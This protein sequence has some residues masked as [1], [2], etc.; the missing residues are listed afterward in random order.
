MNMV[1]VNYVSY[2]ATQVRGFMRGLS[3]E[4]IDELTGGLEAD[5]IEAMDEFVKD[6]DERDVTLNDLIARFGTPETY[7]QELCD[8]A[9]IDLRSAGAEATAVEGKQKKTR[10]L[11]KKRVST[12]WQA[13]KAKVSQTLESMTASPMVREFLETIRPVWW[14]LRAWLLYVGITYLESS[15]RN[16]PFPSDIAHWLLLLVVFVASILVGMK[17]GKR[18]SSKKVI[19]S[20]A[21]VNVCALLLAP[22]TLMGTLHRADDARAQGFSLGYD[23]ALNDTYGYNDTTTT[24]PSG[25]KNTRLID[26][27]SSRNLYVYDSEGNFIQDARIMNEDGTAVSASIFPVRLDRSSRVV[28]LLNARKDQYGRDVFNVFPA[29]YTQI[30][31]EADTCSPADKEFWQ[32]LMDAIVFEDWDADYAETL[33]DAQSQLGTLMFSVRNAQFKY[34]A[35]PQEFFV[36]GNSNLTTDDTCL[37]GFKRPVVQTVQSPLIQTLPKLQDESTDVAKG[38]PEADSAKADDSAKVDDTTKS[39]AEEQAT[40]TQVA[41]DLEAA[42]GKLAKAEKENNKDQVSKLKERIATLKAQLTEL[43]G[44]ETGE[45][46]KSRD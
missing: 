46:S 16:R 19:T 15:P 14:G 9:G 36:G 45:S 35:N 32:G 34:G 6:N 43:E 29:T 2:Y 37:Y 30:S 22:A 31:L 28:E 25:Q 21:V 8:S 12:A 20:L 1:I 38:D 3:P 23:Q 17:L 4:V 42:Q 33:E 18:N 13:A 39:D 40:V 10:A 24:Y 7:A 5:L 11:G 26:V 41:K 44:Q 27:G